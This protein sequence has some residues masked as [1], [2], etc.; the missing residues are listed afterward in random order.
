VENGLKKISFI[1]LTFERD[2]TNLTNTFVTVPMSTHPS[3]NN[4][5]GRGG[6]QIQRLSKTMLNMS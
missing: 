6:K 3:G 1:F 4:W 5:E 2:T